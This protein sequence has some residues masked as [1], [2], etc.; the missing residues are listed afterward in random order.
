[1]PP[2]SIS[3]TGNPN[4]REGEVPGPAAAS[5]LW[6]MARFG[7]GPREQRDRYVVAFPGYN[8]TPE[9]EEEIIKS[10]E[11]SHGRACGWSR[12]MIS[13]MCYGDTGNITLAK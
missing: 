3:E 9:L 13:T 8:R 11:S 10:S 12:A 4:R 2:F 1:M 6:N 7:R 5:D